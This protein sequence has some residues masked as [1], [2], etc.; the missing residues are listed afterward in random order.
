MPSEEEEYLVYQVSQADEALQTIQDQLGR[1]NDP[2]GRV[3]FPRGFIRTAGKL[4]ATLPAFGTEVQR[5]NVTYT[6]MMTDVLR[7]LAVRTDLSGAA[8]SMVVKEGI[9]LLGAVCEWMTKE[10]TRGYASR[11][12]YTQRTEKLVE[13]GVIS[14]TLKEELD[15]VW[16]VR[17]NA[18]VHEVTDLEHEKY[19][20]AD[21]NRALKAYTA[22]R[23]AF[24]D[25][26][27]GRA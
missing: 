22:L 10:G 13:L 6:L 14:R 9:S 23:D 1:K 19:S 16:D 8:L 15:W 2:A 25:H 12:P 27:G 4:R 21:Y 11:R 3:R 26:G 7:W 24:N 5:R 18:H 20:R 17:C